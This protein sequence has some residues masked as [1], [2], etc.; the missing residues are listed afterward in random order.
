M[1]LISFSTSLATSRILQKSNRLAHRQERTVMPCQTQETPM[2]HT[3]RCL[4]VLPAFDTLMGST[5]D[6]PSY[7]FHQ[8]S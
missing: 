3:G 8:R 2:V 4:V 1:I 5:S 7:S 6:L